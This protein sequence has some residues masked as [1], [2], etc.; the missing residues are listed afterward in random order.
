MVLPA[1]A[2]NRDREGALVAH[3]PGLQWPEA[4]FQFFA[5]L[6]FSYNTH[7]KAFGYGSVLAFLL[8]L[9]FAAVGRRRNI[10]KDG[11]NRT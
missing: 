2:F 1:M 6:D 10:W 7:G 11:S 3:V 5:P 4:A 9:A 8:A